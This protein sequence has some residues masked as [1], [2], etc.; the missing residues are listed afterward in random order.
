MPEPTY[1]E[2]VS[3]YLPYDIHVLTWSIMMYRVNSVVPSILPGEPPTNNQRVPRPEGLARRRRPP[4]S[5]TGQSSWSR[6]MF[7]PPDHCNHPNDYKKR[8][9]P[10]Q[11]FCF[12]FQ[13]M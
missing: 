2:R 3:R 5:P 9:M 12:S 7:T 13:P 10:D 6:M 1:V 4:R 11:L 8:D